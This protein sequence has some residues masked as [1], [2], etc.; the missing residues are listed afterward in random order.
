MALELNKKCIICGTKYRYCSNC[1]DKAPMEYWRNVY[2]SV[3]C[4]EIGELWYAQRGEQISK[5]DFSTLVKRKSEVWAKIINADTLVAN[6]IRKLCDYG[7]EVE[8]PV[9]EVVDQPVDESNEMEEVAKVNTI[10]EPDVEET[11]V[12]TVEEP[13]SKKSTKTNYN[14]NRKK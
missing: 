9:V 6:E 13:Q 4:K 12:E 8:K 11:M 10:L 5:K 3:D 7:V 14:K 1:G 2:C